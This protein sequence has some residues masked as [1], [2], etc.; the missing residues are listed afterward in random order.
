MKRVEEAEAR[1]R[2]LEET[3]HGT[4]VSSQRRAEKETQLNAEIEAL[5]AAEEEQIRRIQSAEAR[6]QEQEEARQSARARVK[7]LT[8]KEE[9]LVVEIEELRRLETE[10]LHR[11]EEAEARLPGHAE[12][13]RQAEAQAQRKADEEMQLLRQLEAA[14]EKAQAEADERAAR[15][16]KLNQKLE[17]LHHQ[18][19][20]DLLE[21]PSDSKSIQLV[22]SESDSGDAPW[23]AI[24]LD[25]AK[26]MAP[27]KRESEFVSAETTADLVS[28]ELDQSAAVIAPPQTH[29][30]VVTPSVAIPSDIA[31]RLQSSKSSDR[32][33]ALVDLADGG[34]EDSFGLITKSF[35][36]T[37]VEVRNAAARALY[38]LAPD[39]AASFTRAL[40]EASPERR[41]NIGSAIAGS[42]LAANAI[43]SLSGEGRDRTYDAFSILFLMAKAGEVQPLMQAIA[44]HPNTEVRLTAVKLLALSN[45]QQ[46]LPNLRS[47][48]S[49]DALPEEVHAAVME[50]I[51]T[52]SNQSREVA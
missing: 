29:D 46:V 25:H 6:L 14:V 47:L 13:L 33:A 16:Q 32:A 26:K 9:Q 48:A 8:T 5:R 11:L 17:A 28:I 37:S 23:L 22:E 18:P 51:Y 4:H 1:L 2:A 36:D 3:R 39:L 44:K 30:Y 38:T 15:Q 49:R 43:N 34:G 10:N 42:G 19:E 45:Q 21:V 7:E 31:E 52:L 12:A 24:D 20:V 50:A 41:R 27:P 35:D 40:R